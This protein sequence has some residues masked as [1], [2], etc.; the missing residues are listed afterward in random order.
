MVA[1]IELP[2][3][4]ASEFLHKAREGSDFWWCSQQVDIEVAAYFRTTG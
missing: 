3:V 2:H 4:A 1:T